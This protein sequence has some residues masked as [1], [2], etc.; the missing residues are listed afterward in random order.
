MKGMNQT[1]TVNNLTGDVT[2]WRLTACEP[3]GTGNTQ[4]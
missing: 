3:R 1:A 2:D 4:Q